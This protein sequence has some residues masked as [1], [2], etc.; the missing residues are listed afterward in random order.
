MKKPGR[1][2]P[3]IGLK[4]RRQMERRVGHA[5]VVSHER[6]AQSQTKYKQFK[7]EMGNGQVKI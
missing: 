6:Q 4:S 7:T 3:S 1:K 5:K 2:I